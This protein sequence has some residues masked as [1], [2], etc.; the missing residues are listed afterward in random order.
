MEKSGLFLRVGDTT[1]DFQ[2]QCINLA[3]MK[4]DPNSPE[5]PTAVKAQTFLQ[6]TALSQQKYNNTTTPLNYWMHATVGYVTLLD[7]TWGH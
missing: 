7:W 3:A 2:G 5:V 4:R 1:R 6:L